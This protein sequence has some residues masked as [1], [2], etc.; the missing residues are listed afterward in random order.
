[1]PCFFN[2]IV[3]ITNGK[4][5]LEIELRPMAKNLAHGHWGLLENQIP[6]HKP[7]VHVKDYNGS[8][9]LVLG[10]TQLDLP[11]K[12]QSKIVDQW[13][14]YLI[15]EKLPARRVWTYSRVSQKIFD[16]IC[17]QTQLEGVWIKWGV[18]PD[19]S[20]I[21]NLPSLKYLHLGGGAGIEDISMLEELKNLV[22]LECSHLYKI[23][24]YS[25][26][27][28][29]NRVEDLLIEGD[30]YGSMKKVTLK[31]LNFL[32]QMP[33]LI[34]LSLCMTKIEDHSYLPILKIKSLKYLDL[35]NDKDLQKDLHLFKKFLD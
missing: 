35:P 10:I 16:A 19:I 15:N 21:V 32:E 27:G 4:G 7:L 20:K 23:S 22:S 28:R 12:E 17:H 5:L 13:C 14:D 31:S 24:D 8:D 26:L 30:A 34:R 29:M 33:Q 1:M 11:A 6:E 2:F 25:F 9:D 3:V 18:Y